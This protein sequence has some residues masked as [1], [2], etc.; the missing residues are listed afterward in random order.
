MTRLTEEQLAAVREARKLTS[1]KIEALAGTGKTTT[2]GAIARDL[3]KIGKRG[4][5]LAFNKA[6]VEDVHSKFAQ[7]NVEARTFHSLAFR[8][9]GFQYKDR[10]S[11]RCTPSLIRK[12]LGCSYSEAVDVFET[13][14]IFLST[15]DE[16][17]TY[18][19]FKYEIDQNDPSQ[20][21][22]ADRIID[23]AQTILKMMRDKNSSFPVSHDFYLREYALKKPLI[24]GYDY[25]LFDEAQD[26]DE[27]MLHVLERQ[28]KAGIPIF[29]VGDAQQQI[30]EWR[31][32]INSLRKLDL[33]RCTLTQSFRF[34]NAVAAE[35]NEVLRILQSDIFVRG[36]S[37]VASEVC[38]ENDVPKRFSGAII[39]RFNR[40]AIGYIAQYIDKKKIGIRGKVEMLKTIYDLHA[41]AT[42]NEKR[43]EFA[44]FENFDE[45]LDYAEKYSPA[46]GT[47]IEI[48][49][50]YSFDYLQSILN[51]AVDLDREKEQCDI[52]VSTAHKSKG[53]EFDNVF[54]SPGLF[55][56]TDDEDLRLLYVAKTR[57]KKLL[58][59]SE[60]EIKDERETD[61]IGET[62]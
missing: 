28:M 16:E 9:V 21:S 41:I 25:I 23:Y 6:I 12:T 48:Y 37:K 2:L 56:I 7:F 57:A 46:L 27:V 34:G 39:T 10:L 3:S 53:L 22:Y 55:T 24:R 40:E 31:G 54:L 36:F 60:Q 50:E 15:L 62:A 59:N 30:Y 20:R 35:A 47:L 58:I 11:A 8:T 32:A 42:K 19:H 4:L 29:F 13:V 1:L 38:Y 52:V 61:R 17:I 5:Y 18:E 33:P 51:D 14:H 45:V 44:F 49:R 26:A 43:G